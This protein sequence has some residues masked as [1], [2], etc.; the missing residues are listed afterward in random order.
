M[1]ILKYGSEGP[2]VQLLQLALM[3]PI[4]QRIAIPTF[5]L[6][7][8]GT[9][10]FERLAIKVETRLCIKMVIAQSKARLCARHLP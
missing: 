3:L 2:S 9:Y 10:Q 8:V 5:I 7:A 6:M 1:K 4:L